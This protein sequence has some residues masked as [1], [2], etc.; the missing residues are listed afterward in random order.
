M[1]KDGMEKSKIIQLRYIDSFK[2]MSS[3]LE[4][5]T[6]NLVST[7]GNR[8]ETNLLLKEAF[9]SNLN[10]SSINDHEYS[11]MHKVWKEF[12]IRNL[13]EYH[14]LYLKTNVMLLCNVFESFR[15]NCL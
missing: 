12:H 1:D 11:C 8:C 13:G 4:A 15:D 5:L 14:N 2:F 6:N 3:S 9:Y 10:E 7:S